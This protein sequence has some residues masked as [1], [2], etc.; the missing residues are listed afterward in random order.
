MSEL[1]IKRDIRENLLEVIRLY[2]EEFG[3][4]LFEAENL[5]TYMVDLSKSYGGYIGD[6]LV[7]FV[8]ISP[9]KVVN[10]EAKEYSL[11]NVCAI[12]TKQ[13]HRKKGYMKQVLNYAVDQLVNEYDSVVIQ[14]LN[15]DIYKDFDLIDSTVKYEYEYI[16]GNYPTPMIMVWEDPNIGLIRGIESTSDDN[17]TGIINDD[18]YIQA[19]SDIY[20]E[21]GCR[22]IANPFAYLW[23]NK[24]NEVV[25]SNYNDIIQ[26]GWLLHA[27]K[28]KRKILLF[29]DKLPEGVNFLK[30]L[31][32]KVVVTKTFSKSKMKFKNLKLVDFLV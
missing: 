11:V 24:N 29:E 23:I 20:F 17:K 6:E 18:S 25:D 28:I 4:S 31:D 13:S 32:R 16:E 30:P 8:C 9:R 26:L 14:A 22:F 12:I 1:V 2:N 7:C 5:I 19:K 15:W 21:S 3:G 10:K 27:A